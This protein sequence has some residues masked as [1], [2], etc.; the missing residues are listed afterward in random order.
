MKTI[1]LFTLL[2][3]L[4]AFSACSNNNDSSPT[5]EVET[6]RVSNL[7]APQEGGMGEP[8]S[9]EYTK[10]NFATG[11][12]TTSTTD[13][14]IAFRGTDI[15]LNG[16]VSSG[17]TDEP[18]RSG[19]AAGYIV[20]GTMSDVTSVNTSLLVQD[21][22]NTHVL[23]NWY[24]YTG[25]PNHLILPTAGKILVIKTRDGKYAKLE[26]LSYYKDAPE[27]ITSDI[28]ANDAR[29]F[30]FNFVYQPNAGVTSFE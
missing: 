14:D 10:F 30:T 12:T 9:G 24:T 15:I 26:I 20:N 22:Q 21:S 7:F 19:D 2:T 11:N 8:I 5:L 17:A 4:I 28:A 27:E 23:Q 18:D 13:W 6:K 25:P 1:N 29:Y 16:G 3:L